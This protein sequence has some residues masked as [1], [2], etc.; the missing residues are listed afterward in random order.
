[1]SLTAVARPFIKHVTGDGAHTFL[2]HDNWMA[3]GPLSLTFSPRI[4]ANSGFPLN[5]KVSLVVLHGLESWPFLAVFYP[6]FKPNQL[7]PNQ[8]LCTISPSLTPKVTATW[9]EIRSRAPKIHW[10]H[11]VWFA[12]SIPQH[13]FIF[14][15]AVRGC[16]RTKDKIIKWGV[17]IS[18]RCPLCNLHNE[19]LNH[20]F[21][22]CPFSRFIWQ[23]VCLLSGISKIRRSWN[24]EVSW[25][26]GKFGG[27]R[28]P[29][30][31]GTRG[32]FKV[33]KG[34]CLYASEMFDFSSKAPN[35]SMLGLLL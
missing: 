27:K 6:Y 16:L 28:F 23:Q 31:K 35:F 33:S 22:C 24:V 11:V 1:M 8:I 15:L 30:I 12:M 10:Q 9:N 29:S 21:C 14:W 5:A 2:W 18:A 4:M 19:D 32:C 13:C 26:I 34:P 20:L 25:L 3:K 7:G 17:Q